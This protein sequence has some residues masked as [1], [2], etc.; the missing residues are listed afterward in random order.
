MADTIKK[1]IKAAFYYSMPF[2]L[3]VLEPI[4][5]EF[6]ENLLS[7][8]IK[9]IEEWGPDFLFTSDAAQIPNLRSMCD[10]NNIQIV[11]LRHGVANKY[12]PTEREYSLADYVCGSTWDE[13]DFIKCNVLPRKKFL[14][15]GNPWVDGV[16]KIPKRALNEQNPTVLFAPTYNPEVSAAVFLKDDLVKIIRKIYPKSRIIIKPHPAIL[17]NDHFYVAEHR[18]LFEQL[19]ATW[20]KNVQEYEDVL[21]VED[22]RKSISDFYSETDILI[23]DGSSLVFEFMA[24]NRPILLYTSDKKIKIWESIYDENALANNRRDVGAEFKS[25]EEFEYVIKNAFKLHKNKHSQSQVKFSTEIFGDFTDGNS[26]KRVAEAIKNIKSVTPNKNSTKLI[27]MYLPQYHP[28]PENDIAWG[29]GFTEWTNVAKANPLFPDHYQP[30]LPS[31]LGFYDL[32][33]DEVRNEQIE[34]AKQYGIAGF[35]YYYYWFNGKQV[36]ETPIKKL[37]AN[38]SLDFP[39]CVCWANENWTRKWDGHNDDII[40]K[41][42]HNAED[43]INF[44]RSLIPYFKDERY[45]KV[46]EKPLLLIYRTELFPDIKQTTEKWREEVRKAGIEDLYLVRVESFVKNVNPEDIGFDA[47][48]EFAPDWTAIGG[49]RDLSGIMNDDFN[50]LHVYD[51]KVMMQNMLSRKEENYKLFRGVTPSW[52]NT[53][54]RGK[55]ATVFVNSSPGLYQDWLQKMI[56]QTK[57]IF[58]EEEQFVFINAWN[59]WAEGNHLEPDNRYGR[60]YLEATL[61]ALND[62]CILSEISE[63]IQSEKIKH[64][65]TKK[66]NWLNLI[67]NLIEQQKYFDVYFLIHKNA[68]ENTQDDV[69]NNYSVLLQQKIETKRNEIKW[70]GKKSL[71][72]LLRAEKLIEKQKYSE[73]QNKLYEILNIELENLEA[74]NDLSV[75]SILES[76]YEYAEELI[77]LVLTLDS[78]NEIAIGNYSYLLENNL[79]HTLDKANAKT[80]YERKIEKEIKIYENQEIVHNLPQNH[81]IYTSKALSSPLLSFTGFSNYF[82]WWANELDML[83]QKL[84]RKVYGLSIGSGNGD[85]EINILNRVKNKHLIEFVGVDINPTM[86][87]RAND[88]ARALGLNSLRFMEGDFND[89]K[90]DRDYD[91]FIANHSLHHVVELE[92]LFKVI[93]DHS[94]RNMI[95]LINDMIGRNGHVLW[96]G[97]KEV[98]DSIWNLIEPKYRINAYSKQ[99][100]DSVL[101]I[102]C[103]T[104]GFEGIRAEDILPLLISNFDFDIYIPFSSVIS[105]FI[106]RAYGHNYDINTQKDV[107]IISAI[108]D[109]DLELLANCELSATQAFI[110]LV[111]KGFNNSIKYVYQTPEQTINA[112]SKRVLVD[113][114]LPK[115]KSIMSK[116]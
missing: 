103:S 115:I 91:F 61:N 90:L 66:R 111:P 102:D 106:D 48:F 20:K 46:K 30:Q 60:S 92:K 53:A 73:A 15:T 98:V 8:N 43:D 26:Y 109:L 17:D 39:F 54:R 64:T 13:I 114:Y 4:A 85:S 88:S 108:T 89:L 23:S 47:A 87:Q 51:Y 16:F 29:K 32:R 93:A 72:A 56:E 52:D 96:D 63:N 110:K 45:I 99:V 101:N 86:I 74:L 42:E 19:V 5:C 38:K 83:T 9:E 22:S 59:E 34:M 81:H 100:D 55:N 35:C 70:D 76:N 80:E 11:G 116:L 94:S 57:T 28:I 1:N 14:I 10:L 24:L 82:D 58:G 79:I 97:T 65:T 67:D 49:K 62:S 36:L 69:I 2:Q 25:K 104:E 107:E 44:I 71:S 50:E 68:K 37:L 6:R 112:R 105:R 18:E 21:L 27:A 78:T 41:Q 77:N 40:F 33:L 75:I 113:S 12:I 95:F 31:E 3:R 84:S 7:N